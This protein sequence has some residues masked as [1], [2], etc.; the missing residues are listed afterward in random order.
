MRELENHIEDLSSKLMK[1]NADV[2]QKI[3]KLGSDIDKKIDQKIEKLMSHMTELLTKSWDSLK[4]FEFFKT[5]P[6]K[7]KWINV[8]NRNL[9]YCF[10]PYG[11]ICIKFWSKMVICRINLS[12]T[13]WRRPRYNCRYCVR[14]LF[15]GQTFF[16]GIVSR[17]LVELFSLNKIS[18]NMIAN[19]ANN[20]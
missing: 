12:Q 20:G 18:H 7:L 19:G 10:S 9:W 5:C 13:V 6:C 11:Y 16:L 17:F 4:S 15:G 2:D 14:T 1:F 3:E 8:P